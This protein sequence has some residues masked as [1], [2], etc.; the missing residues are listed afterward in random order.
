MPL[1]SHPRATIYVNRIEAGLICDN[2]FPTARSA[3]KALV[4][5]GARRV[6]VTDG[7][8]QMAEANADGVL[9]ALPPQVNVARVTGA[10][11]TFMAAHIAAEARGLRGVFAV[12]AALGI[13][14]AYISET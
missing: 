1:L 12:E 13:T 8:E 5:Y 6:L 14:A 9:T 10:G 3:A 2:R 11:D 4:G 7:S